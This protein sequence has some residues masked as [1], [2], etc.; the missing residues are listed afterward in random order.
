MISIALP[1][2]RMAEDSIELFV[3]SG[4]MS[5]AMDMSGRKLSYTDPGS[6]LTFLLVRSQDV[7]TYVE[8]GIADLGVVGKDVLL[9]QE[10][11]VYELLDLEFGYCRICLAGPRDDEKIEGVI[12]VA[13]KYPRVTEAFFGEKGKDVEIIKLYG[14]V[15]LGPITGLTHY[16]VDLVSTGATLRENNLEEKETI[17]ESTARLIGN[18]SSFAMKNGI[19]QELREKLETALDQS[20]G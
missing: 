17:F 4:V 2:G 18:R 9:E 7:A 1:K 3:R 19:I 20:V 12:R 11:N 15:E 10:K 16:I 6:G 14:S 5:S 8:Y 13:S